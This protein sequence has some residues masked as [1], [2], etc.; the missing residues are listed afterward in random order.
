MNKARYFKDAEFR[1]CSPACSIDD[2]DEKFLATLDAIRQ[3]AG[4]PLVLN[5]AYRSKAYDQSMGRTGNS[6]HTY[7]KAVDIR[8]NS[9]AN[10]IKIVKAALECGIE[11]IG[12]GS[13]FIHIDSGGKRENL[14]TG[15]MWDYYE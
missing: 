7:G 5:S 10:R 3:K 14:P 9:S 13:T 8:C 6:A 15:V 2:M 4:I 1:K 12:I 11:R